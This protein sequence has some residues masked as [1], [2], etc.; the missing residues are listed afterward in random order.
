MHKPQLSHA[1]HRAA[2]AITIVTVQPMSLLCARDAASD[3][4]HGLTQAKRLPTKQ[5]TAACTQYVGLGR[6]R[7][8]DDTNA[9][10]AE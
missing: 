2:M 4:A 9:K 10:L 3:A 7:R 1:L 8:E 6:S 5:R